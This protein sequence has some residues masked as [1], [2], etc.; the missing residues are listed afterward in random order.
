MAKKSLGE[1]VLGWFVIREEEEGDA[2]PAES[3]DEADQA[4]ME[5]VEREAEKLA[6]APPAK[7]Q[8]PARPPPPAPAK[9]PVPA[10]KGDV[11]EVPA[12]ATPD[13]AVFAKV[14]EAA[15]ISDD[16]Q[17]RVEKALALLESLPKD[18]PKAIRK[19]IVEASLKAFGIPVEE[20]IESAAQ[21][22]QALEAYIQQGEQRTQSLLMDANGQI[23][24]LSARIL[25]IK[26]LMELQ[27]RTQQGVVGASNQQKLRIQQV[28]EFFG[29]EAVARVVHDSPKLVEPD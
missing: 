16:E 18:T 15:Q 7:P 22:I 21:E 1:T 19:Q 25:E 29:Q 10:L 28:L 6:K 20:I 17:Q 24:K 3:A 8:A 13:A 11:P 27:I 2:P 5:E 26:K 12:G 4:L 9:P 23:E 14:Y